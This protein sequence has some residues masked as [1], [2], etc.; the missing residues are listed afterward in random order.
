MARQRRALLLQLAALAGEML[1]G[2]GGRG[3]ANGSI[4][5]EEEAA[6]T[7]PCVEIGAPHMWQVR[8]TQVIVPSFSFISICIALLSLAFVILLLLSSSL[9]LSLSLD[10]FCL[11]AQNTFLAHL[12]DLDTPCAESARLLAAYLPRHRCEPSVRA[13][14]QVRRCATGPHMNDG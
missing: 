5:S 6:A 9:S 7:M 12:G 1:V 3:N 8:E 13:R 2:N 11:G 14:Y 4:D 10:A